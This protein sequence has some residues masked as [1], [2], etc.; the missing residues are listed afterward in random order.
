MMGP[1]HALSGAAVWLGG[2]LAAQHY[3]DIHQSPVQLAVGTAMCAGGALLPDLDLSGRV[4]ANRGGATV[5]RTLGIVTLFLAECVEKLS[6]LV[7]NLT[8]MKKDPE[9]DNGHRTLTHTLVYNVAVGFG[10]VELCLHFGKWAVLTVLFL[11]FAVALRGLF[12]KWAERVGWITVTLAAAAATYGAYTQLPGGRGYPILGL[13]IG[14]GG[15]VH[16][17][18]DMLTHHGCPVLWPIPTG[19]RMW[20]RIGAP[21]WISIKAGGKVE[22]LVLRTGFTIVSALAGALLLLDPVLNRLNTKA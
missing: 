22:V 7:Y 11:A 17:L 5:A 14:V 16:V 1:S 13:A 4:T 19:R 12:E 18:G 3:L 6:L 9:R 2:S 21:S 15:I 10:T 20:R 8:R